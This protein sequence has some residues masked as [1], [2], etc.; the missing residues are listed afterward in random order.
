MANADECR[1]ETREVQQRERRRVERRR[2]ECDQYA[3][4]NPLGWVCHVV[5]FFEWVWHTVKTL[6]RE[7]VCSAAE[8]VEEA[9]RY[10]GVIVRWA[11]GVLDHLAGV[12]IT[13]NS[14]GYWPIIRTTRREVPSVPRAR[15]FTRSFL[16][17]NDHDQA[18]LRAPYVPEGVHVEARLVSGGVQWSIRGGPFRMTDRSFE[19]NARDFPPLAGIPPLRGPAAVSYDRR[20]LGTWSAPPP[21]DM[22]AAGGDRFIAKATGSD[23]IY[24]AIL[25]HPFVHQPRN[26]PRVQLPQSFF[27]LD[28]DCGVS[29]ADPNELLQ[30]VSV[31]GDDER[32]LATERFPLFRWMF[33]KPSDTMAVWFAP[34]IW[35]KLDARPRKDSVEPPGRYPQYTH[36][37]YRANLP[38]LGT[39]SRERARRSIR[40][41]KVLDLGV[42]VSHFHEQHDG[43]FGGETDSLSGRGGTTGELLSGAREWLFDGRGFDAA[44]RFAN[45]P[46]AD[47]GGWVDGTCIYFMLVQ[48]K[49]D[50]QIA[51]GEM[52]DAFAVLWTDEQLAFTERW[53]V[54]HPYD[55]D[56]TSPFQ[57]IV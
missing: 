54:L 32:H 27:K 20:R 6:V 15:T 14:T 46:V 39:F 40:Y 44:Y 29:G 50:A 51:R 11:A 26:A 28:P 17:A 45:G 8:A 21:F 33:R 25:G 31:A 36:V 47:F 4:W 57:P 1:W 34:R 23:E 42:G 9:E 24:I 49:S 38:S 10:V 56:F 22:I 53:R 16:L 30:H 12:F 43:R 18:D 37:T 3:P 55:R 7:W 52:E 48:L 5:T 13:G 41:E 35:V 19:P 2:R